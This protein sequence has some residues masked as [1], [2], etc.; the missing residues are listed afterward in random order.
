MGLLGWLCR[1]LVQHAVGIKQRP[2]EPLEEHGSDLRPLR[3][4]AD[5]M[6]QCD[7]LVEHPRANEAVRLTDENEGTFEEL[8]LVAVGLPQAAHEIDAFA[9]WQSDHDETRLV[10]GGA[11]MQE[12]ILCRLHRCH[13]DG[14]A[15]D[16]FDAAFQHRVDMLTIS[17][18]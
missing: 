18:T 13:F 16:A 2:D 4:V 1:L 8:L 17:H 11:Q 6:K 14:L 12:C 7:E 5:T 15:F 9:K 3:V 10:V